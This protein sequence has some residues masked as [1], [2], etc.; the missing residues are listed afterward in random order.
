MDSDYLQN[1]SCSLHMEFSCEF[2]LKL[3]L[4]LRPRGGL[5]AEE[6]FELGFEV[7]GELISFF[8]GISA[9]EVLELEMPDLIGG[10]GVLTILNR[11]FSSW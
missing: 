5:Q 6:L 11:E 3:C 4:L 1:S 9:R 7:L 10:E 2:D 8:F